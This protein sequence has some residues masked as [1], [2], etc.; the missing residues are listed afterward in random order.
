MEAED[1]ADD[2]ED[3]EDRWESFGMEMSV[4]KDAA[5]EGDEDEDDSKSMV[6]DPFD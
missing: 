2:D 3:T 5:A 6:I 4:I 1:E